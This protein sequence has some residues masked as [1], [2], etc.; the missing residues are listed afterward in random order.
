MPLIIA[1][2]FDGTV[3]DWEHPKPGRRMGPPMPGA[4]EALR[5]FKEAGHTIVI[6]TVRGG[7]PKH[8]REWMDYYAIPY[9]SVTNVKIPADF[10]IDDRA[11]HFTNWKEA[12]LRVFTND[13][14]ARRDEPKAR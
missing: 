9:D 4:Q 12:L 3:H 8:V 10:Y 11:I 5:S 1:V 13:P 14:E 7:E 2:D 6:F